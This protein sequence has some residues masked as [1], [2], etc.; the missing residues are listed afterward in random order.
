MR[1]SRFGTASDNWGPDVPNLQG[2]L[3]LIPAECQHASRDFDLLVRN[4]L[5]GHIL[6]LDREQ[7]SVLPIYYGPIIGLEN[8]SNRTYVWFC[9]VF[10]SGIK[11]TYTYSRTPVSV[12]PLRY[13]ITHT[14]L[15]CLVYDPEVNFSEVWW[16]PATRV[17]RQLCI[18]LQVANKSTEKGPKNFRTEAS[19]NPLILLSLLAHR[20]VVGSF[21]VC[22]G[23][24]L[25]LHILF[26]LPPPLGN[27]LVP[28]KVVHINWNLSGSS[29]GVLWFLRERTLLQNS[30]CSPC[31]S[32]Y[33]K[34]WNKNEGY[35]DS[36]SLWYV[37]SQVRS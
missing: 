32:F 36:S 27:E 30:C 33:N 20:T 29:E 26:C 25:P 35:H 31:Y 22:L 3:L 34:V 2:V 19:A 21:N 18:L 7:D 10:Y 24:I 16:D 9:S 4:W 28:T 14:W 5:L 12:R 13:A 15:W 37:K 8:C 1:N 11:D 23:S 17:W 6:D